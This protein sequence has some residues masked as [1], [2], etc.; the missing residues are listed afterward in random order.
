MALA[1][2]VFNRSFCPYLLRDKT[3]YPA[4]PFLDRTYKC[5]LVCTTI[6][7]VTSLQITIEE[8]QQQKNFV[9]R[10]SPFSFNEILWKNCNDQ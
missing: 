5:K 8:P 9:C 1:Y 3:S 7:L 4:I 2:L 6:G 10:L